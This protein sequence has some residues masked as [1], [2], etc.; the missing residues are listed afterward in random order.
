MKN[1]C[2]GIDLGTT[3][4]AMSILVGDKKKLP[5]IVKLSSGRTTMPSC[6]MWLGGDNYVVGD[7]AYENRGKLNVAY[8]MKRF[9]GT[10]YEYELEYEGQTKKINAE[11]FSTVDIKE[12]KKEL[13]LAYGYGVPA[14]LTITCPA[15]FSNQ[16]REDTR[17]AGELAGWDVVRI[18]NEPTS[19]TLAYGVE[20]LEKSETILAF[21][22]GGGTF[23]VNVIRLIKTISKGNEEF[24]LLDLSLD[25]D[26][27][28]GEDALSVK[29]LSTDGDINLGG[30]DF[31]K[32]VL[33]EALLPLG[34]K[35]EDLTKEEFN[36]YLL[37]VEQI[38]KSGVM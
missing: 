27:C 25:E 8:S 36:T 5:K 6:V 22:L 17:K 18:I 2:V 31:D 9:M 35:I 7:K 23:D 26:D 13:G 4:S 28:K 1:L 19:A 10:T 15:Y 14:K 32:F 34:L 30:D 37:R 3:N 21:D 12:L 29:I 16:Q 38:K 33:E 24:P 20:Q 11:E